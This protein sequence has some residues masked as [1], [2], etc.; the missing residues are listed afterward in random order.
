MSEP[1]KEVVILE[2]ETLDGHSLNIDVC[3]WSPVADIL[4]TAG[5]DR[6]VFLWNFELARG[7]EKG[8][9]I[10]L[11]SASDGGSCVNWSENGKYIAI[12]E[13]YNTQLN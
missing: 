3:A 5:T 6:K 11:D 9:E 7:R 2:T 12:G 1:P 13:T 10:K 8:K 4:V